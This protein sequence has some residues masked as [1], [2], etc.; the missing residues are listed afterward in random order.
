MSP[1]WPRRCCRH[2]RGRRC[3]DKCTIIKGR[4]RVLQGK[5]KVLQGKCKDR[6]KYREFGL[7]GL[8]G[9]CWRRKTHTW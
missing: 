3:K 9:W 8:G 2:R 7:L 5:C 4:Y 1:S 6:D